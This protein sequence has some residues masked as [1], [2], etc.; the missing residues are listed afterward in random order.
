MWVRYQFD[1]QII[2]NEENNINIA[3]MALRLNIILGIAKDNIYWTHTFKVIY[4]HYLG[5][6]RRGSIQ[7][8]YLLSVCQNSNFESFFPLL[9]LPFF[10]SLIHLF[11]FFFLCLNPTSTPGF[12]FWENWK[13][14]TFLSEFLKLP[15]YH[16]FFLLRFGPTGCYLSLIAF[17][18]LF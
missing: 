8:D 6:C 4:I 12:S 10:F 13:I 7:R 1:S 16:Q 2:E 3:G 15:F 17:T 9:A 11:S 18:I 14:L 5:K